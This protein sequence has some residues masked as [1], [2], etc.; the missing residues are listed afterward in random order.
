MKLGTRLLAEA[1]YGFKS[2]TLI[3]KSLF[4]WVCTQNDL[5][6]TAP[7][8]LSSHHSARRKTSGK[9]R[10]NQKHDIGLSHAR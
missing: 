4:I 5:G 1:K 6:P 9:L 7:Q 10:K 8:A 3:T 2:Q